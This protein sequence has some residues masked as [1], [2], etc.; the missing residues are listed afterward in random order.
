MAVFPRVASAWSTLRNPEA[1]LINGFDFIVSTHGRLGSNSLAEN[2]S[3]L[4]HLGTN[5]SP[6]RTED[7]L[8][9]L[10]WARNMSGSSAIGRI[11]SERWINLTFHRESYIKGA[12]QHLIQFMHIDIRWRPEIQLL[13]CNIEQKHGTY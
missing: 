8:V 1:T 12:R 5:S 13:S 3:A 2:G 7:V 9:N 11:S 4:K 10:R 6:E